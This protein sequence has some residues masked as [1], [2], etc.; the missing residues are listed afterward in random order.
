LEAGKALFGSM[1]PRFFSV[2]GWEDFGVALRID[3]KRSATPAPKFAGADNR[4]YCGIFRAD[5]D[6]AARVAPDLLRG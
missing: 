6:C 2:F 3:Q 1:F 4:T 5:F